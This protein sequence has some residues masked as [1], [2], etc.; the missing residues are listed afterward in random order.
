M[1]F[2]ALI[3]KKYFVCGSTFLMTADVTSPTTASTNHSRS[4]ALRSTVYWIT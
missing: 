3:L 1:L 4:S 2:L